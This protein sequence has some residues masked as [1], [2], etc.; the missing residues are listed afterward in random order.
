MVS[1]LSVAQQTTCWYLANGVVGRTLGLGRRLDIL[2]PATQYLNHPPPPLQ[3]GTLLLLTKNA[4]HVPTSSLLTAVAVLTRYCCPPKNPEQG[5]PSRKAAHFTF[6]I[7][8]NTTDVV[9]PLALRRRNVER[10]KGSKRQLHT[11]TCV[12]RPS[13]KAARAKGPGDD[14]Y[15]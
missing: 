5:C 15:V 10:T 7:I 12:Q 14:R 11:S 9:P 1:L 2:L 3:G 6:T 8:N 4:R 13:H